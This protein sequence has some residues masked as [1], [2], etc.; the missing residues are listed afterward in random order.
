MDHTFPGRWD[1]REKVPSASGWGKAEGRPSQARVAWGRMC[2]RAQVF[3]PIEW[4][5]ILLGGSTLGA[6]HSVL[7]DPAAEETRPWNGEC[8][9]RDL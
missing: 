6:C 8:R 1:S 2:L 9:S 7:G 3:P 4:P 5:G